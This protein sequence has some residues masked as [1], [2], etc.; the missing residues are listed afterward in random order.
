MAHPHVLLVEDDDMSRFMMSELLETLGFSFEVA[1]NGRECIDML[2]HRPDAFGAVLMD[3][4]MPK[5][6]GLEALSE[7]RRQDSDPPKNI[8][9][10]AVSA[11]L[12]WQNVEKAQRAGFND[13]LPKP[14][15]MNKITEVLA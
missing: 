2:S 3:I 5:M 6:T 12:D 8:R 9:V 10:V 4:H 13:V 1:T 11:D 7:I 15:R 14:V